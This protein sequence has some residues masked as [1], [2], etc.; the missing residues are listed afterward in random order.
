MDG[1]PVPARAGWRPPSS[2]IKAAA[3]GARRA[4]CQRAAAAAA[5]TSAPQLL[6]GVPGAGGRALLLLRRRAHQWNQRMRKMR[7]ARPWVTSTREVSPA[8]RPALMSRTRWSSKM[9]MLLQ[10]G[11]GV[12][13]REG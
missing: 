2:R 12:R 6:P 3:R 7:S 8:K 1:V 11:G 13:W 9:V 5:A 10:G 4:G